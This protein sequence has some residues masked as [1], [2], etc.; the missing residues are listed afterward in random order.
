MSVENVQTNENSDLPEIDLTELEESA[1]E[2]IQPVELPENVE[3]ALNKIN[4]W[5][6]K[7]FLNGVQRIS[8][9]NLDEL[10]A[11][12]ITAHTTKVARLERDI[13]SLKKVIELYLSKDPTFSFTRLTSI[14]SRIAI[15]CKSVRDY[16]NGK[17]LP[18]HRIK[19]LTGTQD[20][21][22]E[23]KKILAQTLGVSGWM[24]DSGYVGVTAYL[25][26]LTNRQMIAATNARPLT[27]MK[28][29]D[30]GRYRRSRRSSAPNSELKN[31]ETILNFQT[32]SNIAM[33]EFGGASFQIWNAKITQ[34]YPSKLSLSKNLKLFKYKTL[35]W[36]S[37][38]FMTI[39]FDDWAEV[40]DQIHKIES[41]GLS[42]FPQLFGLFK[43]KRFSEMIHDD[44]EKTYS[45]KV[46]DKNYNSMNVMIPDK[47]RNHYTIETFKDLIQA[48]T[49][50]P[51]IFGQARIDSDGKMSFWPINGIWPLGVMLSDYSIIENCNFTL[52]QMKFRR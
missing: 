19:L 4:D 8:K 2:V 48:K 44:I 3:P 21:K 40:Q 27:A 16:Q 20:E 31:I 39:R 28:Y 45:F 25:Y 33:N 29:M 35:P 42:L 52:N 37:S 12:I 11:L 38:K 1:E 26:D 34:A 43:I 41:E 36:N 17:Q 9:E 13:Q 50:P 24:T 22:K 15:T 51:W 10:Q 14:L 30:R 6:S 49:F 18:P 46:Y 32:N 5:F 47:G 23:H 7:I